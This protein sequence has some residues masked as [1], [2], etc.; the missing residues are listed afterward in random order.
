MDPCAPPGKP[1]FAYS[2]AAT[3]NTDQ[4]RI[5]A[6]ALPA[7]NYLGPPGTPGPPAKGSPSPSSIGDINATPGTALIRPSWLTPSGLE[8]VVQDITKSAD[9]VF[10]GNVN[11]NTSLTPL[12]MNVNNPMTV[13]VNGNLDLTSWHNTGFGVL[14]VTGTLTYDPDASWNGIVLVIGQGVFVSTKGGN[15]G[16]NGAM[17]IAK[18]RDASGNLLS[19]LGPSSF[20]QTGGGNPVGITFDSC[21][22]SAPQGVTQTPIQGPLTYKVL[23][24]RELTTPVS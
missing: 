20:S 4:G 23:S 16:F 21:W 22:V 24:F 6:A 13:V 5:V 3:N 10:A 15:G 11:G 1:A 7:T 9:V 8:S 12:G 14:L 18:T 19:A 17:F 2:I